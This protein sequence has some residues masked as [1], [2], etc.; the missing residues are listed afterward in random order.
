MPSEATQTA[1]LRAQ[2]SQLE[3][4]NEAIRQERDRYR[5]KF[6]KLRNQFA[7]LQASNDTLECELGDLKRRSARAEAQSRAVSE[8]SRN[9]TVSTKQTP[10]LAG[11]I[12]RPVDQP[13]T[14][15]RHPS[16]V[17]EINSDSEDELSSLTPGVT[18]SSASRSSS[19]VSQRGPSGSRPEAP[20]ECKP[21]IGV[22]TSDLKDR[23]KRKFE[24]D[25]VISASTAL[26]RSKGLHDPDSPKHKVNTD[27]TLSSAITPKPSSL[28]I[29][30]PGSSS[31]VE[32]QT[33]ATAPHTR[34]SQKKTKLPNIKIKTDEALVLSSD[35]VSHFLKGATTLNIAPVPPSFLSSRQFIGETYGGSPQVF[36]A[37]SRDR[38]RHFVFPTPDINPEMPT[39]PGEAGLLLSCRREM[40]Q[41][42]CTAFARIQLN[43][44]QWIYLGQYH[45]ILA[46]HLSGSE[47]GGQRETVK[48]AW[49][50]KILKAKKWPVYTAI[51]AR[52]WLRKQRKE[53][54]DSNVMEEVERIKAKP[55]RAG[56]LS[57]KD[58]VTSLERGDEHIDVIRMD[59]VAYDHDFAQDMV[60]KSKGW[61]PRSKSTDKATKRRKS[62]IS[63]ERDEDSEDGSDGNA[64]GEGDSATKR[65]VRSTRG[66]RPERLGISYDEDDDCSEYADD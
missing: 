19:N 52:I 3:N 65:P 26:K 18:E 60:V 61:I 12:N 48:I 40:L 33:S 4:E 37:D 51:R 16:N 14:S 55:S 27:K 8:A 11:I 45:S 44:A 57:V 34:P 22:T 66:K 5:E 31:Q 2:I 41:H 49:A 54:S 35:R 32:S 39:S 30:K 15:Q 1:Q 63:M 21:E 50:K 13:G 56:E 38:T 25:G 7:T 47:F 53:L 46:G 6:S 64:P 29:P 58:V 43:P 10:P 36:M 17:V 42:T 23:S 62:N 24:Q 28:S 9:A 59:C 20:K